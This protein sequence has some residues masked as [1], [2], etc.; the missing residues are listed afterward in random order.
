M[1]SLWWQLVGAGIGV[2]GVYFIIK[3]RVP[4]GIEGEP[5][6]GTLTGRSAVAVGVAAVLVGLTLLFRIPHH[7]SVDRC[8]DAGGRFDYKGDVCN[9]GSTTQSPP[10]P[11]SAVVPPNNQL[12][13]Q[14]HE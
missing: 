9:K 4:Y 6:L 8:L 12:E 2:T 3:R 14:R 13:P 11:E 10:T 7:F 1:E 5:P